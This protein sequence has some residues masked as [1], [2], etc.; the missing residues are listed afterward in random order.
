MSNF[1]D[2]H[3]LKKLLLYDNLNMCD[4]NLLSHQSP[5]DLRHQFR[6]LIILFD[7]LERSLLCF[8][9]RILRLKVMKY[10]LIL[11]YLRLRLIVLL[12]Y[13]FFCFIFFYIFNNF[14]FFLYFNFIF[15]IIFFFIF[16]IIKISNNLI[17]YLKTGKHT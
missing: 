16:F 4:Q 7:F 15:N 10:Y 12:K 9:L 6:S 13:F 11:D 8:G 17:S 1:R 14:I 3:D 2:F 5:T